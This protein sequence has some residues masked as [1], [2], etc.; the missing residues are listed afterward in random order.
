M[1]SPNQIF[2]IFQEMGFILSFDNDEYSNWQ[3]VGYA[4]LPGQSFMYRFVVKLGY[5]LIQKRGPWTEPMFINSVRDLKRFLE[6]NTTKP[7]L[8]NTQENI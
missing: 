2:D 7:E 6:L 8:N 5:I 1:M 4:N 3:D